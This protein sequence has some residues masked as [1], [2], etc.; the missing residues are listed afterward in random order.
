MLRMGLDVL[1]T[2]SGVLSK[3]P[4]SMLVSVIEP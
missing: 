1:Q 2:P 3:Y 4:V